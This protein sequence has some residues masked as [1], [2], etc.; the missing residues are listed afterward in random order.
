MNFVTQRDIADLHNESEL[1]LRRWSIWLPWGWS[2]KVHRIVMADYERCEHDHPWDFLRVI[3]KGGYVEVRDGVEYTLRPW[4]PWTFWRVYPCR[5]PFKHRIDRLLKGDNWTLA[6][7]T[8]KLR[9]W[10]F[11]TRD[12][13]KPDQEFIEAAKS[14]KIQ[15]CDDGRQV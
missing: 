5:G 10:G 11:Y 13:W 8:P 3:L 12:G 1:Y 4:R 6:L 7:C 9:R 14:H 15:W 2:I